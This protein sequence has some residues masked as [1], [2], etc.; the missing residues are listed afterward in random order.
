M[1]VSTD[2]AID[3]LCRAWTRWDQ[4]PRDRIRVVELHDAVAPLAER[5]GVTGTEYLRRLFAHR[6]AGCAMVVCAEK[7]GEG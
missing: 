1:T 5:A 2:P 6:R 7:A 4:A 3:R